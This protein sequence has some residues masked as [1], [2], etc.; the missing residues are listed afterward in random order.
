MENAFWDYSLRVYGIAGVEEICLELQDTFGLDVNLVLY[1][2]WLASINQQLTSQHLASL[3]A[4][5]RP[6]RD[7]VIRPLRNLRCTWR[8]YPPAADLRRRL[9]ELELDAE[10]QQQDRMMDYHCTAPA[11]PGG[12]GSLAANL[13]LIAASGSSSLEEGDPLINRLAGLLSTA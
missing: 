3:E 13:R 8:Q 1:A 2:A 7:Q 11:L 10:H 5:I 6:W 9:Q 4:E 12:V